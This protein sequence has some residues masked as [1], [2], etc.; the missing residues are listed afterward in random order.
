MV[1][2][3]TGVRRL[4][5]GPQP[6]LARLSADDY[7]ESWAPHESRRDCRCRFKVRSQQLNPEQRIDKGALAGTR[8]PEH[9]E[10]EALL[11]DVNRKFVRRAPGFVSGRLVEMGILRESPEELD[12]TL[13]EVRLRTIQSGRRTAPGAFSDCCH[14]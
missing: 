6:S 5:H 1:E 4:Q 14:V 13:D 9:G 7:L 12:P 2:G 11:S 8:L 10:I 3:L